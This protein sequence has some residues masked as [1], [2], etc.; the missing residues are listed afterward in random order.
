MRKHSIN[1]KLPNH[2]TIKAWNYS[3]DWY[4]PCPRSMKQSLEKYQKRFPD[5]A[6]Y[7]L[8]QSLQFSRKS[9]KNGEMPCL[10]T[11]S[12]HLWNQ[13][14][15]RC[16]TG[17]EKLKSLLYPV[18]GVDLS[19]F[20]ER[21]LTQFAGNGMHL[22]SVG[23][24]FLMQLLCISPTTSWHACCGWRKIGDLLVVP[25]AAINYLLTAFKSH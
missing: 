23:W 12:T 13:N 17:K 4:F 19:G 20:S 11:S 3:G 24:A 15:S 22:P 18:E 9:L 6:V 5:R 7:D 2:R 8:S 25:I 1:R 21:T 10:A 16:Y 14:L